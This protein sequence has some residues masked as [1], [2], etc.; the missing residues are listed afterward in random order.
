MTYFAVKLNDTNYLGSRRGESVYNIEEARCYKNRK[1]AEKAAKSYSANP[2]FSDAKVVQRITV[3]NEFGGS[4][5][6]ERA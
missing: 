1:A 6:E 5:I 2:Y 3:N 4:W